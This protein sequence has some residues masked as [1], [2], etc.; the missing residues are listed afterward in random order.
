[1][2]I[3]FGIEECV[4]SLGYSLGILTMWTCIAPQVVIGRRGGRCV[5]AHT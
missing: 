4:H 2:E 5:S 3:V 1:M